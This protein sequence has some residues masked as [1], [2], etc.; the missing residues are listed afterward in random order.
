M[1]SEPISNP[2][3]VPSAWRT[4]LPLV[5]LFAAHLCAW[6]AGAYDS[7]PRLDV[8][9]HLLGGFFVAG[10]FGWSLDWFAVRG[11]IGPVDDRVAKA[12][13]LCLVTIVAVAWE[14]LEFGLDCL[15]A[16]RYQHGL[17][18]T[19]RDIALGMAGGAAWLLLRAWTRRAGR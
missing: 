2:P 16:T 18:D 17:G 14:F 6:R 4:L 7:F 3:P 19:L 11:W 10:V 13:V 1:K 8:A 5:V 9:M 12:T 15:F